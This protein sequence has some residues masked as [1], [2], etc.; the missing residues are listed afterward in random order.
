M[1]TG[2]AATFS[3]TR[4]IHFR[5]RGGREAGGL[6][7]LSPNLAFGF[8]HCGLSPESGRSKRW[9]GCDASWGRRSVAGVGGKWTRPL[10]VTSVVR[11]GPVS[12]WC[13]RHT[14]VN[15][16]FIGSP[17]WLDQELRHTRVNTPTPFIG[18][19]PG[20]T[21]NTGFIHSYLGRPWLIL[22]D[23]EPTHTRANTFSI[24]I[25]KPLCILV[26]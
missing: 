12:R 7:I 20:L 10:M 25:S 24:N 5:G 6:S 23:Q 17:A 8:R 14:R 22:F 18:S 13:C 1:A 19:W 11:S 15:T 3:P 4:G 9:D 16:P 26:F 21:K 2:S